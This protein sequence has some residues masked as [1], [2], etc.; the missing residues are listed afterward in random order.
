[1]TGLPTSYKG[2]R[3]DASA[4][5]P[6]NDTLTTLEHLSTRFDLIVEA[7]QIGLWDMTVVAGDPVNPRNEFWW[8]EHFRKMLGFAGERDF[9][10]VLESWSSRLHPDDAGWVLEAFAAH[11]T[12]RTG[13]TPYDV[14]YRLRLKGGEYRWF[15]AT[16]TTRRDRDGVPLR[17]AGA[18]K[19]ITDV[20]TMMN[21]IGEYASALGEH[22]AR[23]G[24]VSQEMTAAAQTTAEQAD[25]T[26]AASRRVSQNV[27]TAAAAVAKM[28]ASMEEVSRSVAKASAVA[29]TGVKSADEA[30]RSIQVLGASSL[31]IGKVVRVI[32]SIAEQTNLLALN[33]TIEA[34]RAGAAGRG[35]SVVANEVKELAKET[36][37]AT[38]DIVKKIEAI[39]TDTEKAVV[40]IGGVTDTIMQVSEL[41]E[42]MAASIDGQ[43]AATSEIARNVN[44]AADGSSDVAD[45]MSIVS[46]A[47]KRTSSSASN[48]QGAAASLGDLSKGLSALLATGTNGGR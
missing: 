2:K 9:P 20:K 4:P 19:D 10:N 17:V 11:L 28:K 25:A 24:D 42:T 31:E 44:L 40:A 30:N 6:S 47:A 15:R 12:D 45:N 41:Q 29:E 8:S 26:T 43:L 22:A 39:R 3:A 7:S 32:N 1:M 18:L 33:A 13:R 27:G 36:R 35:F 14:E 21:K 48:T 38:D 16:G 5:Q 46:V 23:L 37:L 34:A